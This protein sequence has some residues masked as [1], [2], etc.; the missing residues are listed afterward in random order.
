MQLWNFFLSLSEIS[1]LFDTAY[2]WLMANTFLFFITDEVL[3]NWT[4]IVHGM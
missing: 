1:L 3:I 4:T 2:M